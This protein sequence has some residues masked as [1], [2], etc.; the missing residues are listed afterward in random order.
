MQTQQ[1]IRALSADSA[2][3]W[4]FDRR[5]AIAVVLAILAAAGIFFVGIG[6]RPDISE[7]VTTTRFIFKFVVTL[8]VATA[9]SALLVRSGRP[10]A[11]L[12]YRALALAIA[13]ALLALATLIELVAVPHSLW[14]S[15][16]MGSN[17]RL[18]LT[19]I[20]LLAIGPLACLLVVLR[21]GASTRPGTSGAIAGIAASGIAATFYAANCTDDSP[22]F[23]VVWYSLATAIVTAAGF[24]GGRRFLTW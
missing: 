9:A 15:R 2:V 8:S 16:L 18:C 12:G 1:L 21:Q 20:P 22:L 14:I 5:I 6:F 19:L 3:R 4:A 24:W 11:T 17:A 23:V 10:G 7:A 13:P